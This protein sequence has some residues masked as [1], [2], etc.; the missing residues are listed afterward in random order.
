MA[1]PTKIARA[2]N[3]MTI[4]L[5]DAGFDGPTILAFL[6]RARQDLGIPHEPTVTS[7]TKIEMAQ[8]GAAVKND[9]SSVD[10]SSEAPQPG[11]AHRARAGDSTN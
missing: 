9:D 3:L 8:L 11:K 2:F 7:L 6:Q 4:G 1:D 5:A 10:R